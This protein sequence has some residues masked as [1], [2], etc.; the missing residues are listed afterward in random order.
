METQKIL[1][2]NW[3]VVLIASV[4]WCITNAK[5]MML[6]CTSVSRLEVTDPIIGFR[7]QR[8]SRPCVNAILFETE[9]GAFCSSPRQ[10][11]VRSK[12]MQ[13]L[14]Q[15]NSPT[16]PLPPLSSAT[17]N[18]KPTITKPDESK[19]VQFPGS[20]FPA[21]SP[22][23]TV[24]SMTASSLIDAKTVMPCCTSVSTAEVTD[25]IISVRIQRE[26]PPCGTSIIFE[27]KEGKICSDP[28]HKW[29]LRKVVQFLTQINSPT[30]PLPPLSSTT[31]N[32]K[33]A[34]TKPD[35]SKGVQFPGS[36]FPAASPKS[37]MSSTTTS[38]LSNYCIYKE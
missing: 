36:T 19:G 26:S 30:S 5:D 18:E 16:S 27:T 38:S 10:P 29:V 23:S 17:S 33:T 9:R 11:W 13:F 3:A 12:V 14:A 21:A 22:K 6:C 7:I 8:E 34:I 28:R 15:R 25:P 32:E 24:S 1:V 31:S 4:I 35:E 2:L 20:S 37:T